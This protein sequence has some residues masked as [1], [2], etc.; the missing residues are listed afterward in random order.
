MNTK[1]KILTFLCLTLFALQTFFIDAASINV[2]FTGNNGRNVSGSA[3]VVPAEKW[4]NLSGTSGSSNNLC[5]DSGLP[6]STDLVWDATGSWRSETPETSQDA[7]LMDGYLAVNVQEYKDIVLT[8]I[9]FPT[10]DV[11]VYFGCNNE[12]AL[13]KLR[14]N[15]SGKEYFYSVDGILPNFARFKLVKSTDI[16]APEAGNYVKFEKISGATL[17]IQNAMNGIKGNDS[18]IM[19]FQ[20]V[21]KGNPKPIVG[22]DKASYYPHE[23]ITAFFNYCADKSENNVAIVKKGDSPAGEI[24]SRLYA[25]GGKSPTDKKAGGRV[26]FLNAADLPIGDYEIYLL[27]DEQGKKILA[28]PVSFA[29]KES[30]WKL[31]W[32]DEFDGAEIDAEKWDFE[33]GS[34]IW[35]WGTGQLD[36]STDRKENAKVEDGKL[37]LNILK[38]DYKGAKYTSSRMLTRDKAKFKYGRFE[39]Y[40]KSIYSQGNGMAFWMMGSNYKE[41]DWGWPRCGEIDILEITGKKPAYNIGT[42][43]YQE[44]W[45]HANKQGSITLPGDEKFADDYHIF[46]LEWDEDSMEFYVDSVKINDF[47]IS[48]PIDG[49]RPFNNEF[50]LILSTGVGGQNSGD[51]DATSVFP[52]TAY[53]DW[54]RVYQKIDSTDNKTK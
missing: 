32:N 51:P 3:G 1:Q 2:N 24:L 22:I 50:Y 14:L 4:S 42:A 18:G 40:C 34:G 41:H 29:V 28:G 33:T 27:A 30:P 44:S 36:H 5:D 46:A 10:Y 54:I 35:G 37:V 53:V 17:K 19:G 52:M 16:T 7:N 47:D 13:G 48:K 23:I 8:N 15:G 43:H 9:P 11:Y 31:V 39:I 12:G 38:E 26:K 6:T 25:G 45:G 21:S 20:I 49:R